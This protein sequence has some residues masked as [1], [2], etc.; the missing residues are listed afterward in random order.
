[1]ETG[2]GRQRK[3]RPRNFD[4]MRFPCT[5][6]F[7]YTDKVV[8]IKMFGAEYKLITVVSTLYKLTV[9]SDNAP[10]QMYINNM[11]IKTFTENE[12]RME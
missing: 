5:M 12:R 1:M 2:S 4:Q 6:L 8:R 10:N 9:N 7:H 3:G 11:M